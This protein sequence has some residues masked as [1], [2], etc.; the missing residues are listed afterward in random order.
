MDPHD[1]TPSEHF[2]PVKGAYSPDYSPSEPITPVK[3]HYPTPPSNTRKTKI[4]PG[5][6][7]VNTQIAMSEEMQGKSPQRTIWKSKGSL[8]VQDRRVLKAHDD[9]IADAQNNPELDLIDYG[10]I[11]KTHVKSV[12]QAELIVATNP[13]YD[14]YTDGNYYA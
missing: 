4:P 2:T 10:Q 6:L 7:R 8:S 1:Y 9:I 12:S 14:E 11:W 5:N 13:F 3:H